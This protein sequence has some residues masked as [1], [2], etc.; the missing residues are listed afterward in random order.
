[1]Y[2][3]IKKVLREGFGDYDRGP[4][5]PML[6]PDTCG[7]GLAGHSRLAAR[8]RTPRFWGFVDGSTCPVSTRGGTRLVQ[9]V[10]ERRGG[11]G[12]GG[13]GGTRRRLVQHDEGRVAHEGDRQAQLAL[14]SAR[15]L[16]APAR[17]LSQRRSLHRSYVRGGTFLAFPVQIE[18]LKGCRLA[19][20]G[21][22]RF[23]GRGVSN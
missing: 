15:V 22:D 3:R 6:G 5:R 13:G 1:M 2:G 16:P 19:A 9:L 17:A 4:T 12:G 21:R 20:A 18:P 8:E 10:R 7:D 11:G 14:V 23:D